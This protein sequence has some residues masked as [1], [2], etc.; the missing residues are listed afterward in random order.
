M[1]KNDIVLLI[2]LIMELCVGAANGFDA[3]IITAA[4]VS[5]LALALS[6]INQK[7]E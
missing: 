1:K 5:A 3:L 7:L 4:V 2:L 6:F